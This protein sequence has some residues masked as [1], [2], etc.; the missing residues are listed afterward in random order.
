[1]AVGV[2]RQAFGPQKP[3]PDPVADQYKLYNEA[4]KRQAGDYDNIMGKFNELYGQYG[5]NGT[6]SAMSKYSPY[7]PTL[8]QYDKSP[9]SIAALANLKLLTE[10]GGLSSEDQANLRARGI[11]PIRAVYANAQRNVNR[12]RSLSGGYSPNFNAVT[13]KMARE[14]SDRVGEATTNVNAG[15]AEMVQKGKLSAAPS[16]A[17]AA[18]AE[19]ELKNRIMQANADRQNDAKRFNLTNLF[20]A[21]KTDIGNRGNL[22]QGMTSL[23]GT[24]PALANLY[25]NQA[26]DTAKFTNQVNQ[27]KKQTGLGILGYA[28]RAA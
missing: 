18:Q 14:Q 23:Y 2:V 9:D 1:M 10:T 22:L 4:V 13:A 15:I 24:T 26:M 19:T 7:T 21:H 27:Q 6:M 12:Q 3:K 28:M 8:E 25:G 11:S 17:T 20:D 16:Y 5:P